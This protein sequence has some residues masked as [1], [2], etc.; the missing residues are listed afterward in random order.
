MDETKLREVL[1]AYLS[2]EDIE[3]VIRD[4]NNPDWESYVDPRFAG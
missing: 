3:K 1:S 4:Y 2:K